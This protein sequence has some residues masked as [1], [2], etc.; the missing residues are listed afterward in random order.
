MERKFPRLTKNSEVDRWTQM[1]LL[2]T[3][4]DR[5]KG[6]PSEFIKPPD[7]SYSPTAE[8][9]EFANQQDTSIAKWVW[10]K[11]FSRFPHM[12]SH[13]DD[14]IAVCVAHLWLNR[15]K[16]SVMKD[17]TYRTFAYMLCRQ[18]VW[19]VIGTEQWQFENERMLSLDEMIENKESESSTAK[20]DTIA[21]ANPTDEIVLP[22]DRELENLATRQNHFAVVQKFNDKKKEII[23]LYAQ[24]YKTQEIADKL[25]CNRSYIGKVKKEYTDKITELSKRQDNKQ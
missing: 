15:K 6:L 22:Q 11:E 24:G 2:L 14:L 8:Y 16:Y 19:K 20:L 23:G 7:E 25:K 5:G 4:Q 21:V 18:K 17:T 10:Y 13:K 1:G 3:A 9:D 12:Q